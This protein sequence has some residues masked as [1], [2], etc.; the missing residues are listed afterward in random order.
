MTKEH[1]HPSENGGSGENVDKETRDDG[2]A[3]ATQA[4][5][6]YVAL[7]AWAIP[8]FADWL[9]HRRSKIERT[10]GTHESLTHALMM[11]AIGVPSLMAL[12]LEINAS[13]LVAL[14]AGCALH[15]AIVVWDVAYAADRREVTTTEQHVHS[16]LEVL[17][18]M[19]LSFVLCLHWDQVLG[20]FG[21]GPS[22]PSFAIRWKD[23][24]IHP[25]YLGAIGTLLTGLVGLPYAE[26][27][28]R[29]YRVDRTFLPHP[30]PPRNRLGATSPGTA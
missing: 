1:P 12:L 17:P 9:C 7:P 6:L 15:E 16:F 11:T 20:L 18:F 19:S 8:G 14:T 13:T 29:C 30:R 25:L 5:L 22:R 24:P 28:V 27:L 23:N 3:R 21:K 10:S 26:E 4:F 2:I